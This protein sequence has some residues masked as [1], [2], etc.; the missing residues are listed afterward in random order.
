M[1]LL[2]DRAL[3]VSQQPTL[4]THSQSWPPLKTTI[5][6]TRPLRQTR[7]LPPLL[8]CVALEGLSQ[9]RCESVLLMFGPAEGVVVVSLGSVAL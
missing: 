1:G 8:P 3:A 9:T 2:E 4:S 5:L 7:P 6:S